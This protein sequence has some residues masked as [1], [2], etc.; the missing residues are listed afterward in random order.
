[1][2]HKQQVHH[3]AVFQSAFQEQIETRQSQTKPETDSSELEHDLFLREV[4]HLAGFQKSRRD[5]GAPR[6]QPL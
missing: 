1:M 2:Q 3:F 5:G 4:R 6:K